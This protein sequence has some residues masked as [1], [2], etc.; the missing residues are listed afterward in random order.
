MEKEIIISNPSDFEN[1]KKKIIREG[2]KNLHIVTDFD[3]TL[4][5]AFD[6]KNHIH[7][8]IAQIR[9]GNY[10]NPEYT[11]QAYELHAKYYPSEISPT[12]PLA[13]K[14]PLMEKWWNTHIGIIA[15]NGM[16]K[17]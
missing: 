11:K 5:K 7:T 17:K 6:G 9:E 16:N 1:K 14:M 12:I 8:I 15:S 4:T 13:E 10:L 3:K 2:A